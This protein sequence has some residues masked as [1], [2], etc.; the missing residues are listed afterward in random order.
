[1]N[2]KIEEEKTSYNDIEWAANKDCKLMGKNSKY[3]PVHVISGAK[4]VKI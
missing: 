2:L 1:L 4:H 3:I